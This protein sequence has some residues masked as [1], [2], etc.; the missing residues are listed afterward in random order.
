VLQIEGLTQ[1]LPILASCAWDGSGDR[2]DDSKK[3]GILY[4]FLMHG[5]I[6]DAWRRRPT[7]DFEV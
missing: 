3:T 6:H 7:H 1:A 5:V 4:S 2:F